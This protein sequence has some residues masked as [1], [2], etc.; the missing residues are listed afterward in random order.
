MEQ[1]QHVLML[2]DNFKNFPIKV[3]T[4]LAIHG[5]LRKAELTEIIQKNVQHHE[6]PSGNIIAVNFFR[7]K[8]Q[9]PKMLSTF[10]INDTAMVNKVKKYMDMLTKMVIII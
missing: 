10:I 5:F 9:G 4:I 3:A 6:V 1:L 8:Q 2:D 7:K